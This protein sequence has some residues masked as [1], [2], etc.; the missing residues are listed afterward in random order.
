MYMLEVFGLVT[1]AV[2]GTIIAI[3]VVV[4]LLRLTV[5]AVQDYTRARRAIERLT[6]II[7]VNVVNL[8]RSE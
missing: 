6:P 5:E 2:F 7:D 1:G 4:L 8:N 3:V